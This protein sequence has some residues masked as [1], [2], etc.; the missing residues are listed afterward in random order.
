MRI[1]EKRAVTPIEFALEQNYPNPF[2]PVTTISY[3]IPELSNVQV[4]I[5]DI[6]GRKIDVLV[7]NLQQ[8]GH[9]NIQ[10]NGQNTASG[11]YFLKLVHGG[12]TQIRKMMLLK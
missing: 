8:A 6:T 11:M 4:I 3:S 7:D 12:K 2:N 10:W 9:Y 5:Y 1:L